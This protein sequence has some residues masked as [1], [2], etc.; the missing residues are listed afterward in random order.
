MSQY[1]ISPDAI[2]DLEEI[3]DYFTERNGDRDL[4]AIFDRD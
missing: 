3:I 1:T 4:E 2:H